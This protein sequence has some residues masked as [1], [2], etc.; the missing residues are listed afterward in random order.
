MALLIAKALR[1]LLLRELQCT[2]QASACARHF[3]RLET[4]PAAAAV[5]L[6]ASRR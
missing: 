2:Q 6:Q 3:W 4:A 5:K 1:T